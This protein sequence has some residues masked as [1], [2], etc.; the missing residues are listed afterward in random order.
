MP[1]DYQRA[2]SPERKAERFAQ[3]MGAADELVH[4]LP[5]QEI[6]PT[7]I[8]ERLGW[9]RGNLYKYAATKEEVFLALHHREE[10]AFTAD[11]AATLAAC[12][13]TPGAIARSWATSIDAHRS[14]VRYQAVLTTML[15]T[16]VGYERLVASKRT[17]KEDMVPV[18]QALEELLPQLGEGG[19][20][21]LYLALL[22]HA[23]GLRGHYLGTPEQSRA[24][25][26]AGMGRVT[27]DFAQA[28]ERF[29]RTYLAG[30][31][32]SHEES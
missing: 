7:T 8:A 27:D 9:S 1:Q 15:E 28:N 30:L 22:Y 23:V 29:A 14:F 32:A 10:A 11:L 25:E 17:I 6:S 18:I 26:E 21:G 3:I 31:L 24:M 19:C 5:Y 2:R 12:E 13:G 16:N 4:E 20:V